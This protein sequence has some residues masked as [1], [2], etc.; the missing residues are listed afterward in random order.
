MINYIL[1]KLC[2]HSKVALVK[3]SL[4]TET[5]TTTAINEYVKCQ[6]CGKI[7]LDNHQYAELVIIQ[8]ET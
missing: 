5:L 7:L 2:D 3:E 6:T 1:R 8:R 4:N